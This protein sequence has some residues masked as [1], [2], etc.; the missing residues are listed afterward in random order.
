MKKKK[1]SYKFS[2]E[3]IANFADFIEPVI[4]DAMEQL[5]YDHD[6]FG[7]WPILAM[8]AKRFSFNAQPAELL[9]NKITLDFN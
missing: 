8:T 2:Q 1:N 5:N 9:P 3:E 7:K 6:S 4:D